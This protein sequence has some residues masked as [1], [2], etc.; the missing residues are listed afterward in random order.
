MQCFVACFS[1]SEIWVCGVMCPGVS[2]TS[3][4]IP[5]ASSTSMNENHLVILVTMNLRKRLGKM[6]LQKTRTKTATR[7]ITR[8][9]AEDWRGRRSWATDGRTKLCRITTQPGPSVSSEQ[10]FFAPKC[11]S[12]LG[13][14]SVVDTGGRCARSLPTSSKSEIFH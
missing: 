13:C 10:V 1:N 2:E 12:F 8:K 3:G 11:H 7:K 6:K 5:A 9:A 4:S 14:I